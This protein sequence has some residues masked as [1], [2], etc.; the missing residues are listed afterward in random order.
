MPASIWTE[1]RP[2]SCAARASIAA[3]RPARARWIERLDQERMSSITNRVCSPTSASRRSA[4]SGCARHRPGQIDALVEAGQRRAEP[5]VQ[6]ALE[7]PS[8]VFPRIQDPLARTAQIV[9]QGGRPNRSTGLP[10]QSG[11]Q[12]RL[13]QSRCRRAN[14]RLAAPQV[15]VLP[16]KSEDLRPAC[17]GRREAAASSR[18]VR[19]LS[20]WPRRRATSVLRRLPARASPALDPRQHRFEPTTE[21]GQYGVRLLPPSVDEPVDR[22]LRANADGLKADAEQYGQRHRA[23]QLVVPPPPRTRDRHHGVRKTTR[24][25]RTTYTKVPLTQRSTSYK[26]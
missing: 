26:R 4:A 16:T 8:F 24:P 21:V 19:R 1:A 25:A 2:G 13:L 7:R 14:R 22:S 15:V 17:R 11:E 18:S 3:R 9:V 23:D 12:L 6:I 10:G 5:V 20:G